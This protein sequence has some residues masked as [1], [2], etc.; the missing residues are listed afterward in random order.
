VPL[1]DDPFSFLIERGQTFY[2]TDFKR[3]LHQLPWY[4][5]S[6]QVGTVVAVPVR[7]GDVIVGA[8]VADKLET[9]AF[10]GRE[11]R[12]LAGIAELA[13]EAIR[14]T[15]RLARP[16]GARRRVQGRLPDLAA[17]RD[18]GAR[19]RGA[20]AAAALGP[21]PGEPRGRGRGDG[22]RARDSLRRRGR[23]R[24]A[25]G[26]PEAREWASTSARGRPG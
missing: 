18:A 25:A 3:M 14:G 19:A 26:V 11:P 16:R 7:V 6:V 13:S 23:F 8:L 15:A 1:G 2:A 5:G 9:Q 17:A 24:L 20:R 10:T 4:R 22:G 12:I 21:P